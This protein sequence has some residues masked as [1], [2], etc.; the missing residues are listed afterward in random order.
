[1][2]AGPH[3]PEGADRSAFIPTGHH[4]DVDE[5]RVRAIKVFIE[6]TE[7]EA[8]EAVDAIGSALC[9]E[10][11]HPGY[12]PVPWATVLVPPDSLD[13]DELAAWSRS[14]AEDRERARKAGDAGA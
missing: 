5:K 4:V 2:P 7:R 1:M 14:F 8:N 6:A 10:E 13:Q 9:R 3:H 11:N 12:C